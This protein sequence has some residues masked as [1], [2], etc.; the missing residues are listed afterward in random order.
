MARASAGYRTGGLVVSSAGL[1]GQPSIGDRARAL[2]RRR[3]HCR[4]GCG[5]CQLCTCIAERAGV[6]RP[7]ALARGATWHS[8]V[9]SVASTTESCATKRRP[10]SPP[11]AEV[12]LGT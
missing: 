5:A 2:L 3:S 6:E 12:E 11:H 1:V 9:S 10:L 8:L 7:S 4:L